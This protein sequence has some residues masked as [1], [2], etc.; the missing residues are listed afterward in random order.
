MSDLKDFNAMIVKP[1]TQEY[2]LSVLNT[3]KDQFV[4]D[5]TALVANDTNLQACEPV[6]IMYAAINAT[7]LSLPLNKNLGFA[8]AI[9]Y[10]NTKKGVSEAQF[11]M[12]YKGYIQLAIRSGQFKNINVTDIREGEIKA[13]N[14]L[15][16]E[17]EFEKKENR[18]E[19]PIVGYAA[20]FALNNG[21]AKTLY[22][23][24]DEMER[25]AKRYSQTYSSRLDY[26][27]KA[28][29][30]ATDFDAMGK[31]TVLK[32]LLAKY[33]PLSVEMQQAVMY[34]QSV[35]YNPNTPEYRDNEPKSAKEEAADLVAED[36]E[37]EESPEP[38]NDATTP[39]EIKEGV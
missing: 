23:T 29:K 30:W 1:K 16:G 6:T 13:N 3:K 17:I 28:S 32:L 20:Y 9:P 37:F 15:T 22:M 19:L 4:S 10:K 34:D 25:H 35:M 36:A 33:A 38:D 14:L 8:Y 31:K 27:Q 26:V 2:L 5:L 18:A 24:K 21:F 7:A 12:G 11:L 39:F